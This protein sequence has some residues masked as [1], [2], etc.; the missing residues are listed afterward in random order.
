[1]HKSLR[2]LWIVPVALHSYLAHACSQAEISKSNDGAP[3]AQIQP[4][5]QFIGHTSP[6]WPSDISA[7]SK[8]VISSSRDETARV[9]TIEGDLLAVHGGHSGVRFASLSPDGDRVVTSRGLWRLDGEL[10]TLGSEW[11]TS[12]TFSPDGTRIVACLADGTVTLSDILGNQITTL[13]GHTEFVHAARFS[14]DGSRFV[15]ASD[16]GT[17]RVW[18]INGGVVAVLQHPGGM[19]YAGFSPDGS[20]I[21]T[22]SSESV[23]LWDGDGNAIAV[24]PG[25]RR[26]GRK[27]RF[28][29]DGSRFVTTTLDQTAVVWDRDGNQLAVLVGH[30]G[31]VW[32]ARLSQDGTRI[33]TTSED[34]TARLWDQ[35]GG[36]IAVLD[37]HK[38]VPHVVFS[39]DEWLIVTSSQAGQA[40]LW[41]RDGTLIALLGDSGDSVSGAMFSPDGRYIFAG[42]GSMNIHRYSVPE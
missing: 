2:F 12:A 36:L 41:D 23:R 25:A 11:I 14:P 5:L 19:Y 26:W 30:E 4:D 1:M 8:R 10:K 13:Q 27:G 17:A 29:S 39:P 6:A 28:S 21:T 7:D 35:G 33:L 24:L 20:R 9:W 31:G 15:T 34:G 40:R 32:E 22:D 3:T 38:G 16:D 18:D 37:G 42:S